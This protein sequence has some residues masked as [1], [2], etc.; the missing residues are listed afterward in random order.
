[1]EIKRITPG[2]PD[3]VYESLSELDRKCFGAEGWSPAAFEE[4]AKRDGGIV[5]A[6]FCGEK[7]TGLFAGFTAADTGEILSLAVEEDCRGQGIAKALL[8]E[9]MSLI[10][11]EVTTI[12]LEVRQSNA[13]A[14]SLYNSFGFI[15]EGIRRRFYRD[16]VEDAD[17]MVKYVKESV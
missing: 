6:A 17:I 15:K 5:L 10:P 16:P 13:A 8:S 9:F 4:G 14:I 7:L 2:Y 11:D 1:M 12:A 3:T